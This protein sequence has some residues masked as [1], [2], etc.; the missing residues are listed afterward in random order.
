MFEEIRKEFYES[1]AKSIK[2]RRKSLKIIREEILPDPRRV[3]KIE[4][5]TRDAHHPYLIGRDEYPRLIWL[6]RS[7]DFKEFK[8]KDVTTTDAEILRKECGRNYD[9]MLWG[10]IDWDKMFKDIITELSESNSSENLGKL[11]E[12][13]LADYVPYAKTKYDGLYPEC[14]KIYFPPDERE[15]KRQ[16]AIKWVHLQHGSGLFKQTFY[17]KFSCK[18]LQEFDKKFSE[19]IS[20]YLEERKPNNYSLSSQVRAMRINISGY[21]AKWQSLDGVRYG[22]MSDEESGLEKLLREYIN[23]GQQYMKELEEYQQKFDALHVVI[24]NVC[25]EEEH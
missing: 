15:R 2:D 20:K 17:E 18:T 12:D 11:F 24:N 7:K 16:D 9:E 13:T 10:H 22:Y 25:V 19:F 14:A 6:F 3:T 1:L 21:E 8:E 4:N 5:I 23:N